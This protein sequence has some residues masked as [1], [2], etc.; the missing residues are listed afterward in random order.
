MKERARY[1]ETQELHLINSLRVVMQG[2][3]DN[4]ECYRNVERTKL[5]K[6]SKTTDGYMTSDEA[7]NESLTA[8][9]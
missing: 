4:R 5:S 3:L 8:D 2:I 6:I 1:I 9:P 7:A